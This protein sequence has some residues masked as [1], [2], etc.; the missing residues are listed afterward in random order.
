M[1]VVTGYGWCLCP[2][3]RPRLC[4]ETKKNGREAEK[5]QRSRTKQEIPTGTKEDKRRQKKTESKKRRSPARAPLFRFGILPII[6][7]IIDY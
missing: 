1:F 7:F 6:D 2:S 5:E 4:V 3:W